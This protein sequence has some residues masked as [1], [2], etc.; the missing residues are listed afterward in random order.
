ME[1]RRPAVRAAL[2]ALYGESADAWAE[3]I[4]KVALRAGRCRP[5]ELQ[6]SDRER[7]R[8]PRWFLGQDIAGYSCY[9]DHFAGALADLRRRADYLSELG[10][11]VLHLLPIWKRRSGESDGGFAVSDHGAVD[12][13]YGTNDELFELAGELRA[14]RISLCMDFVLNHVAD[15]HPWASAAQRD[16]ASYG[17]FFHFIGDEAEIRAFNASVPSVFPATAPG[18]FTWVPARG[19]WVWTTFYPYQWDLNYANPRVL[20]EIVKILLKLANLGVE[21]FRLDSIPYLWKRQG[22]DCRNQPEVHELLRV[23]RAAV[24]IAAPGVL[25]M[26]EAIVEAAEQR[27][28]LGDMQHREAHLAYNNAQMLELWAALADG[29]ARKLGAQAVRSAPPAGAGWVHYA[30][31]HDEIGWCNLPEPGR[32][33]RAQRLDDFFSGRVPNS[34]STGQSFESAPGAIPGTCGTLASLAGLERAREE[35]DS[36]ALELAR[37]RIWLMHGIICSMQGLPFFFM[38]DEIGLCNVRGALPRKGGGDGRNLHRPAMDWDRALLR[39]DPASIEAAIWGDLREL[40]MRR[41]ELLCLHAEAGL[42]VFPTPHCQVLCM[43]RRT[44]G[45]TLVVLA[46]FSAERLWLAPLA[47]SMRVSPRRVDVLSGQRANLA[48]PFWLEPYDLLW[49]APAS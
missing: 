4:L 7:L 29:D 23:L 14:R 43:V 25:L 17:K 38:G 12:S 1:A 2:R 8:D 3:R 34:F 26:A 42:E 19:D 39:A 18:N 30:R 5:A 45:E 48:E 47:D 15:D 31:C 41:R 22:S 35:G 11:R 20:F 9:L 32:A 21:M 36:K 24:E 49:L 33:E 16:E 10:I 13:R 44:P 27:R 28:Y 37:R 6:A 46:N 40:L